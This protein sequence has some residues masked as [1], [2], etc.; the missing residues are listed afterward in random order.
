MLFSHAQSTTLSLS[1]GDENP[2][3]RQTTQ[4][5]GE[6]P[7]LLPWGFFILIGSFYLSLL[8]FYFLFMSDAT[9]TF[10]FPIDSCKK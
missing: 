5:L 1:W 4:M 6:K 8:S 9:V 3:I 7:F 2:P 10:E